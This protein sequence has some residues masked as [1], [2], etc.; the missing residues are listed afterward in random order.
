MNGNGKSLKPRKRTKRGNKKNKPSQHNKEEKEEEEVVPDKN[1][2]DDNKRNLINAIELERRNYELTKIR[3]VQLHQHYGNMLTTLKKECKS[4]EN[5]VNILKH[6]PSQ[7]DLEVILKQK[8]E[9]K[10]EYL[11]K[12]EIRT[13]DEQQSKQTNKENQKLVI[14]IHYLK[15]Q[16]DA[17]LV[18][19]NVLCSKEA[20][21][22]E[23][24]EFSE[25]QRIVNNLDSLD[26]VDAES[27]INQKNNQLLN[28]P[29]NPMVSNR[30]NEDPWF[31]K[32]S[33]ENRMLERHIRFLRHIIER[34]TQRCN[35]KEIIVGK[36]L[37][38]PKKTTLSESKETQKLKG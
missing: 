24:D 7:K 1:A 36:Q 35:F 11:R 27:M 31:Q 6:G 9:L 28:N 10:N 20:K 2:N 4:L 3:L 5:K 38:S 15:K 12:R 14:I 19:Y 8:Q 32:I 25:A 34:E 30:L 23:S 37:L 29:N 18:Q 33:D 13:K 22:A 17:L 26:I 16:L 21:G